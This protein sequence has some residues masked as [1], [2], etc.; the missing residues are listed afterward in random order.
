MA[1]KRYEYTNHV[2]WRYLGPAFRGI[3]ADLTALEAGGGGG[4]QFVLLAYGESPPDPPE[5]GKI[6]LR[7]LTA[8]PADS[9][10][11]TVPSDLSASAVTATGFTVTW[12]ASTD[13]VAVTGYEYRLD[14]SSQSVAV[15][16][17]TAVVEG[18]NSATGYTFDV[19]ARDAAGNRSGWSESLAVTTAA[20]TDT[21]PP[22]VPSDLASSAVTATGFTLSWSAPEGDPTGYEY[23]LDG[24]TP[25][26]VT[27]ATTADVA[28]LAAATAYDVD[29]RARDAAG[30]WSAWSATVEV[31]TTA[32]VSAATVSIFGASSPGTVSTHTDGP[33]TCGNVFYHVRN[34]ET[35]SVVGARLFVPSGA[36]SSFLTSAVDVWAWQPAH[37][38]AA[39]VTGAEVAAASSGTPTATFTNLVEGWN[40]VTFPAPLSMIRFA[41][42]T[43]NNC[44]F[45]LTRYQNTDYLS[46]TGLSDGFIASADL[47]GLVLAEVIYPRSVNN[48]VGSAPGT[49]PIDILVEDPTP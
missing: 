3:D 37:T 36:P 14:A 8:P 42:A 38:S 2:D 49:Y 19:R 11:P 35:L 1:G 4:G 15:E 34:G 43:A 27:G 26:T 32:A 24:G 31:V 33:A 48:F 25:V 6:Y 22:G 45:I 30:N 16:S 40:E 20:S 23:R 13:D 17:T 46:T 21:T 29:V 39:G 41:N 9:T 7:P 28:G 47:P 44:V 18:L 10:P 5:A 12:A